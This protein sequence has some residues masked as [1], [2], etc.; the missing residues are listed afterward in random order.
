MRTHEEDV[1]ASARMS[2]KELCTKFE[3]DPAAAQELVGQVIE[4]NGVCQEARTEQDDRLVL[5]A[6]R[7]TNGKVRCTLVSQPD[8]RQETLFADLDK[9]GQVTV[10]GLC[11]GKENG[12]VKLEK[13]WL[14][15]VRAR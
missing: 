12:T 1:V 14:V 3:R 9:Q 13:T 6:G 10:K 2:V 8:V 4:V 11:T 15:Y 5:L 7:G